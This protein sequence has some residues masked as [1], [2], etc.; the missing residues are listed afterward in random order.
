MPRNRMNIRANIQNNIHEGHARP[1]VDLASCA[2][3]EYG[4]QLDYD[5]SSVKFEDILKSWLK[6][7]AKEA[8]NYLKLQIHVP[9]FAD[10]ERKKHS[11]KRMCKESKPNGINRDIDEV[12][13]DIELEKEA[14]RQS[15]RALDGRFLRYFNYIAVV[16]ETERS[17][18]LSKIKHQ[19]DKMSLQVMA[20]LHQRY[21]L[22]SLNLQ[23][24]KR[25]THHRPDTRLSEEKHLKKLEESISECSFGLEHIFREFA[26][27]YELPDIT[28]IDYADAAAEM[29]LSGQ[30]LELL[31]GDSCYIPLRWFDAVYRGLECKT[32]NAK[33]FVISVLGI[34][35]SGK[36]TML[37]TMFGLEFPVSAGRCTRGAF[38]SLIPVGDSLKSNIDYVL[39]ID[40]E[41][42][43]GSGDSQLREHD[44]ELATFA[45]G[46]ADVTIVNIFGENHHEMKEFLEIAV[47]AFLKMKLVKEKK[48]C[49]IVHQ[50]VAATDAIDKLTVDRVHLKQ[51]LDKMAIVAAV[52]ENCED[53]FRK[54]DDIISFDENKDVF[55]IPS[56]LKGSPPMAPVN[57]NYG[58]AIQKLKEN[59]ITLMSAKETA[60]LSV[61]QF[62]DRVINL[63]QA[64][65][66]ENFIFSFRNTIEVRAYTSL[67]RKYF[68]ESVNFMV[69]GMA[70]VER[71]IQVALSRCTTRDDR[72]RKWQLSKREIREQAEKLRR[73]MEKEMKMFFETNEDKA[74]LEQWKE[75]MMNKI[76]QFKENQLMAVM[77][78]CQ[79]SFQY[80]QNRQDVEEMKQTYEKK[81]LQ[82]ARNFITSAHNTDD[83]QKCKAAFKQEW[84]QWIVDVPECQER[85]KDIN[86]EMIEVLCEK[87]P[88]L[89]A[90]ITEK[91]KKEAYVVLNF[92]EMAPVIDSNKLSIGQ[93]SKLYNYFAQLQQEVLLSA[94]QIQD[95]AVES[96][97]DFA[98]M[99][100]KSGVRYTSNDLTQM[101][102]KVITTIDQ[103][104]EKQRFKFGK[105]LKCDI[106][107][108][109]F[110]NAYVIFNE[111]EERYIQ[112]RDIRG[113][114]EINLRPR[115]ESYFL[116]LCNQMEKEILAATSIVGVLKK[117]I[118]LELN[119]TM[120]STVTGELL[121]NTMYQSKGPFHA[122]VL[123][124]LGEECKFD[125][126]VPYLKNPVEFLT[127][128]LIE[129]VENYC[130]NE[131]PTFV[132]LLL[133]SKTKM[134]K[135][136]LFTAISRASKLTRSGSEKLTF[137]IQL[138]VESC[139]TLEITK[140]MFAVAAI[141][142]DL[143]DIDLFEAKLQIDVEKFLESLI[144]R[145]VDQ[146]TLRKW[147]PS[148]QDCLFPSMFGCQSCCPF[149]NALCDQTVEDH[150]ISHS[151]RIHRPQGLNGYR[152]TETKILD[153]TICTTDVAGEG[154][155]KN[156]ATSGERHPYKSHQSVNE[157]YASWFI[158]PDPSFEAS[159][160]WQWFMATFSK[161]LAKHYDA[162]KPDIPSAWKKLKF[163]EVKEQL[164]R[165][166]NI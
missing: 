142:E 161:E 37:N 27:L 19:L 51:D 151:T 36:S 93:F 95:K 59:I 102:H 103:E 129:S 16:D 150:E 86:H 39:V 10:L 125:P 138:F 122:S 29:L 112:E 137:W 30:P 153:H 133:K 20:D 136:K 160:Y 9:R 14:Q 21:R 5:Q 8:K 110:A 58:R 158:P 162:K 53:K 41:G 70:E 32:N 60:Q 117:P 46:L 7:G 164:R 77:Q 38:V 108:Y 2:N 57:P 94:Y 148:P 80:W 65:L 97:L 63:W 121:T 126:Y 13:K 45:I 28:T 66:K 144:K 42:L 78:N 145:G 4:I 68:E 157:Y 123:I 22:A 166:Y 47:H 3:S 50:N 140:E 54:F 128:K 84:Q 139:S 17:F 79:A 71:K 43:K 147:N 99:K 106:L 61:S 88:V 104:T 146:A 67:E 96:A 52:Q 89:N 98:K 163:S 26:Q 90:E 156:L 124:E 131:K 18:H 154:T 6:L 127:H 113:D 120:G 81:L 132:N 143:K 130:L 149:C 69:M 11:P 134:I 55:Y 83:I 33:I 49:K 114:L 115:L 34:Q 119:R 40:T 107:L 23:K 116:N 101:C 62:R 135:E 87:M 165:E 155:F 152:G 12:Y 105:P 74:T 100:S 35:S 73:D 48:T 44:N 1:L 82:R 75:S 25:E 24:K 31:D 72:E 91:L 56:L 15:F 141:N 64:M 111:M 109:T 159:T 85:K 76:V 92:K 118:E